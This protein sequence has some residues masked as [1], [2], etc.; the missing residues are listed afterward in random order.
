MCLWWSILALYRQSFF[1]ILVYVLQFLDF[2]TGEGIH[3]IFFSHLHP[4]QPL[5]YLGFGL[6]CSLYNLVF[7][8]F[9]TMILFLNPTSFMDSASFYCT[10]WLSL[11]RGL[12]FHFTV[13]L[14]FI[15]L[16]KF[17][18][19]C[20]NVHSFFHL[21]CSNRFLVIKRVDIFLFIFFL[22]VFLRECWENSFNISHMRKLNLLD[23]LIAEVSSRMKERGCTMCPTS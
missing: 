19:E 18:L 7:F 4:L 12:V 13:S 5:H 9:S 16:L 20:I 22:I 14:C 8:S 11:P 6:P 1:L 15:T 2:W 21:F 3:Y 23:W 10:F 17:M